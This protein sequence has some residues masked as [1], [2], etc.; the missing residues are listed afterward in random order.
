MDEQQHAFVTP[1][2]NPPQPPWLPDPLPTPPPNPPV[3]PILRK[4]LIPHTEKIVD[5]FNTPI[6]M[7]RRAALFGTPTQEVACEYHRN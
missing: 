1:D 7:T 5:T 2:P 4:H 3:P 6:K